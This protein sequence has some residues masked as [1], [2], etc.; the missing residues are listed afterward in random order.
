MKTLKSILIAG[1]AAVAFAGPALAAGELHIYNWGDYTNPD[2]IAKF[3]KQYDVKVSLDTYDSNETMLAKVRAGASGYDIV[4]P[5]DYTVKVMVD[6]GM[7]EETKPNTMENFK[8][9]IPKFVDVYWDSGRNYSVPWQFGLTVFA[10]NTDKYKGPIDSLGILFDPPA[11][12]KGRINMLDDMNSVIH[13]AE[14]YLNLPR[15]GGEKENLK[16]VSE[17]LLKAK[18]N[19]RTFSYDTIPKMTSGDV[20]ASQTWNGAAYRMRQANPAIKF[21]YTK[22]VM[23]GWMDNVVVL[24]G[25]A[26]IENAKLFQNFIMAPENAGL[27]SAFAGYDNGIMDS[28]KYMPNGMGDSPEM[29]MPAGFASEFTPP[30]PKEVVEMYNK[31][32]TNLKK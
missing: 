21:A 16:K 12:L 23:E 24:K 27:I 32:W 3:E 10:V 9:M 20:D 4:V 6:E 18:E 28:H 29:N 17:L 31:I 22:E 1:V 7:L 25:A 2:L 19:W 8:Y 13:A 14:R 26:N 11:E 30:C 5:S 15:C